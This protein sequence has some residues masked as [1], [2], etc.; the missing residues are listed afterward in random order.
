M[1]SM[2]NIVIKCDAGNAE[3]VKHYNTDQSNN[4][5][6]N[7]CDG[8]LDLA[9]QSFRQMYLAAKQEI[10][11]GLIKNVTCKPANPAYP[12]MPKRSQ[13]VTAKHTPQ[14]NE[15]IKTIIYRTKTR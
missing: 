14:F 6:T 12:E 11:N 8:D 9:W 13:L 5:D 2:A 3:C 15:D 7:W 1:W 4:F 10:I